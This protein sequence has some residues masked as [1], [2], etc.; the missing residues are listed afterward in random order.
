[1]ADERPLFLSGGPAG[2]CG[3]LGCVMT[4]EIRSS[5]EGKE[6]EMP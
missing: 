6:V 5:R 1:M 3:R 2:I 4:E